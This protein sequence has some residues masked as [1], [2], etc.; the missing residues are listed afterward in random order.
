MSHDRH[1]DCCEDLQNLPVDSCHWEGCEEG[2]SALDRL[3]YHEVGWPDEAPA[4][5]PVRST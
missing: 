1:P 5:D 4:L 2:V 3:C